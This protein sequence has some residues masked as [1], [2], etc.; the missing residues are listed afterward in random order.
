MSTAHV[1]VGPAST[2][3]AVLKQEVLAVWRV[4]IFPETAQRLH[5]DRHGLCCGDLG[6][7]DNPK[8]VYG[9]DEVGLQVQA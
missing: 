3:Q 1:D 7:L 2:G 5:G 9:M 8:T 4:V 6:L